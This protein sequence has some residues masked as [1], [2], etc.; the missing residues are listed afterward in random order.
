LVTKTIEANSKNEEEDITTYYGNYVEYHGI[1]MPFMMVAQLGE[2][3][4]EFKL[5][6][7]EWNA[8]IANSEFAVP[9]SLGKSK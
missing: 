7:A 9:E 3:I 5:I 6:S 2:R 4:V 8:E 1:V